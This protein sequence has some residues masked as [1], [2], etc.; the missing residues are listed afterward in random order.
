MMAKI[1]MSTCTDRPCIEQKAPDFCDTTAPSVRMYDSSNA[2]DTNRWMRLVLP[3]LSSP[4]RQILN[5]KVFDSGSIVGRRIMATRDT[6]PGGYQAV[7]PI[8]RIWDGPAPNPPY[9]ATVPFP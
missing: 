5:L 7:G 6:R 8:F 9:P 4:T 2:P 3:T 1:I